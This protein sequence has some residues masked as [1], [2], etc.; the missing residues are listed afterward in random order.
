MLF[1]FK[2]FIF[3]FP[4]CNSYFLLKFLTF[5]PDLK[6]KKKKK[7]KKL[8]FVHVTNMGSVSSQMS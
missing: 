3:V 1:N 8:I 5:Y 6:K 4:I 7:K 2:K